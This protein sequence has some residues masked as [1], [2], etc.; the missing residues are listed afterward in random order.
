[1]AN[2]LIDRGADVSLHAAARSGHAEK[3]KALIASGANVNPPEDN[4]SKT[5]PLH[6]AVEAGHQDVAAL[7]L[8]SGADANARNHSDWTPLHEAAL[9]GLRDITA[10]LISHGA[11]PDAK[12]ARGYSAGRTPLHRAAYLG[13]ADIVGLLIEKGANVQAKDSTGQTPLHIAARCGHT[14]VVT[15]L[16]GEGAEVTKDEKGHTAL[17]YARG[18][19][20]ADVVAALGGDA[21]DLA[22]ADKMPSTLIITNPRALRQ[23]LDCNDF[24]GAWVLEKADL[25][26]LPSVL[27]RHLHEACVGQ[28]QTHHAPEHVLANLR[29]YH[30]EYAGFVR[31]DVRYIVC[32]MVITDSYD[33][34]PDKNYFTRLFDGGWRWTTVVFDTRDQSVVRI[35]CH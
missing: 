27:K 10:L 16:V 30:R 5:T 11:D 2:L 31:D 20:F 1:M 23:V 24:D 17:D 8:A 7:L 18:A 21:S 26:G 29:W 32:N 22:L 13:H 3:V 12:V 28:L 4:W 15:R 33:A 34:T 25:E 6:L 9:Y 35:E 19:G 14:V